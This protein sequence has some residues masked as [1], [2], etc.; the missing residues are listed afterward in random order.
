MRWAELASASQNVF[1]TWEWTSVWW[2]HF[3]SGR[4]LALRS[5][6]DADG[7]TVALLPLTRSDVARC[8]SCALPVTASPT[9]LARCAPPRT[10]SRPPPRCA[11][12]PTEPTC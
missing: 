12:P 7:R 9:S 8:G 11:T 5:V 2:R 10:G 4:A 3:G 6:R 1:S